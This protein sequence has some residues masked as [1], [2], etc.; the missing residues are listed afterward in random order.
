M[1]LV[2]TVTNTW[3]TPSPFLRFQFEAFRL[4]M[5]PKKQNYRLEFRRYLII[6]MVFLGTY[7]SVLLSLRRNSRVLE[8]N[9]AKLPRWPRAEGRGGGLKVDSHLIA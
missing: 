9:S 3:V 8:P 1:P 4:R 2:A 7:S 6:L 5:R